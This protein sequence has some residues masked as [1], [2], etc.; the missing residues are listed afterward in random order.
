MP[1]NT[2]LLMHSLVIKYFEDMKRIIR[3]E[4]SGTHLF[5]ILLKINIIELCSETN[6]VS[7]NASVNIHA[8][9]ISKAIPNQLKHQ[10]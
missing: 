1:T 7:L 8:L 4:W 9:P 10:Q 6:S 2:H 3:T 5:P